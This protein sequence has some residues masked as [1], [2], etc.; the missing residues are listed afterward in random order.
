MEMYEKGWRKKKRNEWLRAYRKT[1][2][3][4]EGRKREIEKDKGKRKLRWQEY[5]KFLYDLRVERGGKC[6]MCG[7]C[8]VVGILQFHHLRDKVE[9]VCKYRGPMSAGVA[10]RIRAEADKCVLLCP[11]CHWEITLE[12][13]K[14]KYAS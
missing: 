7:Y 14:E 2:K 6:S 13:L 10:K 8:K 9:E 4:I 11:N 5:K 12:Q 3:G 1:P